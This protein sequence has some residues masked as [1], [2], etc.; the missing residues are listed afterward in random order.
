MRM[1]T[2]IVLFVVGVA[3][4]CDASFS[5]G[6]PPIAGSGVSKEETRTVEAFHAV[7]AGNAT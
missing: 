7:E 1:S 4:G 2:G 5:T 6:P 3:A